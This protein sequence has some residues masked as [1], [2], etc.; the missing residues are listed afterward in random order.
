MGVRLHNFPNFL[1]EIDRRLEGI[2]RSLSMDNDRGEE[3]ND[4]N[5][6]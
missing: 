2:L 4:E 3:E 6:S 1:R 5:N